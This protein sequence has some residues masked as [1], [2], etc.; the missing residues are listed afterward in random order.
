[1]LQSK[2]YKE[3]DINGAENI[4][5]YLT[6]L[7]KKWDWG[8]EIKNICQY[9]CLV[10]EYQSFEMKMCFIVGRKKQRIKIR[11]QGFV[12]IIVLRVQ[13]IPKIVFF[14]V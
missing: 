4:S 8:I 14:M 7:N 3:L 12:L 11:L 2:Y 9:D 6:S 5:A 1:M 10:G 13:L